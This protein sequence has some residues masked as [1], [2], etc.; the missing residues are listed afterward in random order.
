MC[1]C[2]PL[3]LFQNCYMYDIYPL[4]TCQWEKII[5]TTYNTWHVADSEILIDQMNDKYEVRIKLNQEENDLI[6]SN[7]RPEARIQMKI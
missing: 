6:S 3:F 4:Q 7:F 2:K 5:Y 1:Q